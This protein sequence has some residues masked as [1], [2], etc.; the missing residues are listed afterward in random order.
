MITGTK[1]LIDAIAGGRE[2]AQQMDRYLGGD[3]EID[4]ILAERS[5]NPEIGTI[6]HFAELS[7]KEIGERPAEERKMDFDLSSVGFTC[8]NA[9]CEAE[10]CLQCDLR[11]DLSK[12]RMWT[13]YSNTTAN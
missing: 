12:V 7:R 9:A 11:K 4:E 2:A 5:R 10:R 3:G 13:E 6:E 8:E 1:F